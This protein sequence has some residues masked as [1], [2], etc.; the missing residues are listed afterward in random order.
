MD[1]FQH[2]LCRQHSG[3]LYT[4]LGLQPLMKITVIMRVEGNTWR[5]SDAQQVG[6]RW[7]TVRDASSQVSHRQANY[8]TQEVDNP[9]INFTTRHVRGQQTW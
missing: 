4:V 7:A 3:E 8:A 9:W 5:D 1:E 6:N 2:M